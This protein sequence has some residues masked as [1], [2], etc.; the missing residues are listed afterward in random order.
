MFSGEN[1]GSVCPGMMLEKVDDSQ[2]LF[3]LLHFFI[4]FAVTT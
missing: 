1:G 4:F 3:A 2:S